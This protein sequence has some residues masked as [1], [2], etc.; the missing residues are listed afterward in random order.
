[1]AKNIQTLND[2]D[3]SS[4]EGKMLMAA[5]AILTTEGER[6]KNTPD[7]VIAEVGVLADKMYTDK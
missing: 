6:T 7:E 3:T 5:L 2:I 4:V 1:M